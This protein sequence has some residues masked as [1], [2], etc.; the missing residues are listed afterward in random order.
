MGMFAFLLALLSSHPKLPV[1][2]NARG[3]LRNAPLGSLLG[4]GRDKQ[5]DEIIELLVAEGVQ[6]IS[7][8]ERS[9]LLSTVAMREQSPVASVTPLRISL[10]NCKTTNR[11]HH[12][13]G[14]TS[15]AFHAGADAIEAS[16]KLPPRH[17]L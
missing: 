16:F 6:V 11:M 10:R 4:T 7:V 14:G 12:N 3:A 15:F 2:A 9:A 13:H 1:L 17:Q 8:P 5:G